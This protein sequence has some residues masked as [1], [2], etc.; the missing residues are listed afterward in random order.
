MP[1][2][3]GT[4]TI[5]ALLGLSAEG[6][7][8]QDVGF[9]GGAALDPSQ[10][11]AGVELESPPLADRIHLR[12]GIDGSFGSGLQLAIIDVS[13][14]Y[15]APFSP[16]SPWSVYEGTGP[17]VVIS[18]ANGEV[19]AHGGLGGVFGI[20]HRSGF[21]FEFKVASAGAPSLRLGIGYMIRSH[22]P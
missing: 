11:Y 7:R 2:L 9:S 12:P 5:A 22:P 3:L 17:V 4:V 15:E 1:R 19:A 16:R 21:F 18:R 10:S 14:L 8:A 13:F 20:A 6:A